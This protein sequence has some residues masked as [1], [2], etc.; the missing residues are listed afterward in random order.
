MLNWHEGEQNFYFWLNYPWKSDQLQLITC[1]F[2]AYINLI[3]CL[4]F[5][6]LSQ[7]TGCDEHCEQCQAQGRCQQCQLPYA[8]LN[9]LCVLECG[10]HH[11]LDDS[12]RQCS[13][14]CCE[15]VGRCLELW[16]WHV[17]QLTDFGEN[18]HN[19]VP[20]DI[21][22]TDLFIAVVSQHAQLV[23]WSAWI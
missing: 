18:E 21:C 1:N 14:E 23:A 16:S 15:F 4:Q 11:F 20:C 2:T 17:C 7:W 10:K 6:S 22:E 8:V 5:F 12:T 13:G 19:K 9:G 3:L